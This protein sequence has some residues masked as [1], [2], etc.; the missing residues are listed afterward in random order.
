M[1]GFS[2]KLIDSECRLYSRLSCQMVQD[3]E[4]ISEMIILKDKFKYIFALLLMNHLSTKCQHKNLFG[5]LLI[6]YFLML[7]YDPRF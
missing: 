4:R 2:R 5:I 1:Y 6:F 3:F 7:T